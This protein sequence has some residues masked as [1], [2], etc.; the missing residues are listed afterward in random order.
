ME[1]VG[2]QARKMGAIWHL[3]YQHQLILWEVQEE[4]VVFSLKGEMH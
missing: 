1:E 3:E 2:V 4:G